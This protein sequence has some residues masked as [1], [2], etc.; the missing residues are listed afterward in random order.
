MLLTL[1]D[2]HGDLACPRCHTAVTKGKGEW[3]C[4]EGHTF[5][6][7]GETP[8]LVDFDSD[9]LLAREAA[10]AGR[11]VVAR[12]T[13]GLVN[14]VRNVLSPP[15]PA[16][17][18]NVERLVSL[19]RAER[20]P[21][22]LVVGGGT[23]GT[24]MAPLYSD[25]RIGVAAF[26]I[27][28]SPNVQFVADAHAIPLRD[29]AFDAVVVQAVLEHVVDPPRV[30]AEIR[31]VLRPGG[32]V[33]AETP[34]MQQVHEGPY[35]F[36]RFTHSGHRRLFREFEELDSGAVLGAGTQL[37]WAIDYATRAV[38]RSILAGRL[39]RAAF[40]WL[41]YLDRA[42]APGHNLD[43]ASAVYFFGRNGGAGLAPRD[44]VG[45]YRGAQRN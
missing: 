40:F 37:V 6:R 29:A 42:A 39:A 45:Y 33:Y 14:L 15:S 34:F 17:R 18:A 16:T 26:D 28:A 21:R 1:A 24:G 5:P 30:V 41:A 38:F 35:D 44:L 3:S 25:D 9:T 10:T 8:V 43:G 36:T 2:L 22:V 12:R 31:R 11:S 27:Y 20:A 23:V 13:G 32:L 4:A 7:A 19:L